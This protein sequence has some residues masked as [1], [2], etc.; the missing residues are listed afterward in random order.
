MAAR[1]VQE[2]FKGMAGT[3]T[4]FLYLHPHLLKF[5]HYLL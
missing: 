3:V 2:L 4:A 1:R 5:P